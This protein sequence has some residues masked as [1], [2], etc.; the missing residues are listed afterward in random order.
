MLIHLITSKLDTSC[1]KAWEIVAPKDKIPP[2]NVLIQFLEKRFKIIEA[3][4]SVWHI[5][6][7]EDTSSG[8]KTNKK[9]S[10][11]KAYYSFVITNITK[12]YNCG[13]PHTKYK[14]P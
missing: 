13:L 12:C 3:I 9:M 14:W 10:N 1:I 2:I 7:Q 4:E 11:D 8:K 5:V 6:V